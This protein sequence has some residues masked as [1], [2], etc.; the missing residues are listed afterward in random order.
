[1]TGVAAGGLGVRMR[2]VCL[3][4]L[5]VLLA[6]CGESPLA[7]VGERSSGWLGS[8]RERPLISAPVEQQPELELVP[9]ARVRWWNDGLSPTSDPPVVSLDVISSRRN[10][11]DRFAQASRREIAAFF[12]DLE[13][14]AQIPAQVRSVTSQLVLA[15]SEASF[16]GNHIASFGLWTA[17]PYTQS[18]SVGQLATISVFAGSSEDPCAVAGANCTTEQVGMRTVGLIARSGGDTVFWSD[19]ERTYEMFVREPAAAAV[20]AML[21]SIAPISALVES[22]EV[23]AEPTEQADASPEPATV[24]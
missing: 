14:P 7:G 15:A 23:G 13:F 22:P 6:G 3:V 24:P 4:V 21:E 5:V 9:A 1:M 18:R 11:G 12:P 20:P 10:P 8:D 19:T 16:E 17:D 2:R